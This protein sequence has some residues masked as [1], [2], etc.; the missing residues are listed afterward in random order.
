MLKLSKNYCNCGI[1]IHRLLKVKISN[2]I[3][4]FKTWS[5][6]AYHLLNCSPPS[7]GISVFCKIQ[8]ESLPIGIDSL[9]QWSLS[10]VFTFVDEESHDCFGNHIIHGLPNCVEIGSNQRLYHL[11]FH[12][13][14]RLTLTWVVVV[15][16]LMLL[17]VWHVNSFDVF[18]HVFVNLVI[19]NVSNTPIWVLNSVLVWGLLDGLLGLNLITKLDLVVEVGD[20]LV[21]VWG[22]AV[23]HWFHV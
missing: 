4:E 19:M 6:R 2:F 11:G 1:S 18:L 9:D 23:S 22:W 10:S 15:S 13:R 20:Q 21:L 12:V 5:K 8:I 17:H 7:L 3:K 16:T 14:S